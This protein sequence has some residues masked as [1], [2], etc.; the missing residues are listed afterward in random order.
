[1]ILDR[2]IAKFSRPYLK[3]YNI[4]RQGFGFSLIGTA[5]SLFVKSGSPLVTAFSPDQIS[6]KRIDSRY[7]YLFV[8]PIKELE[9]ILAEDKSVIV[10]RKV[11]T[12]IVRRVLDDKGEWVVVGTTEEEGHIT[13]IAG[14][15]KK[16][17]KKPIT[18]FFELEEIPLKP[19]IFAAK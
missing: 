17:L 1:M 3:K 11:K 13:L 12:N 6:L 10:S 8:I 9:K 2:E 15:D 7:H 18:R 4:S 16:A 5:V 14:S 19:V